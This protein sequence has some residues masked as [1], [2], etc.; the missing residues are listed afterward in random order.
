MKCPQCRSE[1][2]DDATYCP[3]CG[4]HSFNKNYADGTLDIGDILPGGKT[5]FHKKWIAFVLSFFVGWTGATYFYLKLYQK[6]WIWLACNVVVGGLFA[7][8][9]LLLQL[10]GWMIAVLPF[11]ILYIGNWVNGL[12]ICLTNYRDGNGELLHR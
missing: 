1:I 7:V 9:F 6:G 2:R 10:D 5:I 4:C 3:H 11:L 12:R 8:L